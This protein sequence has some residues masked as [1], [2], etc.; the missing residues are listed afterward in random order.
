[1]IKDKIKNLI[2]IE[3]LLESLK[4]V[5]FMT[6]CD[7]DYSSSFSVDRKRSCLYEVLKGRARALTTWR[8]TPESKEVT[9]LFTVEEGECVLYFPGEPHLVMPVDDAEISIFVLE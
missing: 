5:P 4:D 9:A 3:G 2:K 6:G 1:M 7:I 8:E